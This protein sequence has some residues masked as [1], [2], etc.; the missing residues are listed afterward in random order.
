MTTFQLCGER[1]DLGGTGGE[2]GWCSANPMDIAH[3]HSTSP[4]SRAN[5]HGPSQ[6]SCLRRSISHSGQFRNP[7]LTG[8][9]TYSFVWRYDSGPLTTSFCTVHFQLWISLERTLLCSVPQWPQITD[10]MCFFPHYFSGIIFRII[11]FLRTKA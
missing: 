7:Y 5:L 9:F 1:R 10:K 3:P 11:H 8:N 6:S 4:A 2:R